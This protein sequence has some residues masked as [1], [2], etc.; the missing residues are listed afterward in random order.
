MNIVVFGARGRVGSKVVELAIKRGH[1]VIPI[2]I[3]NISDDRDMQYN[4]LTNILVRLP[5]NE[6]ENNAPYTK[7]DAV[8]DF[9]TAS[10]TEQVCDFCRTHH[11]A[12]VSGV[13]GRNDEE[14]G[15][16]DELTMEVPVVT[17]A[18]FSVGI[19]M[20]HKICEIVARELANWDCEIVET[21]RSGKK[22][23]PSGTAISLATTIAKQKSFRH[24]VTHSQR[25][26]SNPGRHEVTFATNGESLTFTHQAESVEIFALGAIIEAEKLI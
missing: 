16:I 15:L 2:D 1:T 19:S 22:D 7:I 11:C 3:N 10:A 8:I 13:T 21:H 18:N 23:A 20:L 4:N 9:S 14:Q 26:G 12:L 25:L 24:V 5:E 17:K 6:T